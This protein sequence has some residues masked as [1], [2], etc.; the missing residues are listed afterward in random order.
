MIY[1]RNL[2]IT[3]SDN[4]EYWSLQS[5]QYGASCVEAAVLRNVCWLDVNGTF[6]T[7]VLTPGT[8]YEVVYVV[9]LE[10]TAS[11]WETPVNLKLTLPCN[12]AQE[13]SVRLNVYIGRS[14]VAIPAGEF[15]TT[16][17]N[18]GQ[19]SFS[20]YETASN[21]WKKGLIV[22]GVEIRPKN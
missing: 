22:K 11:G 18:A 20:M 10:D 7:R 12:R 4:S 13:R 21:S 2:G 17:Q 14:W 16:P 3:W 15:I 1:A 9:K 5:L 19:I 8:R 6:D